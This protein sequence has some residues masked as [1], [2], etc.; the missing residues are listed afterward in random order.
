M[1][2]FIDNFIN[3]DILIGND[4]NNLLSLPLQ[5]AKFIIDILSPIIL[6]SLSSGDELII[7]KTDNTVLTIEMYLYYM[8]FDFYPKFIEYIGSKQI[9]YNNMIKEFYPIE[10]NEMLFEKAQPLLIKYF[11]ISTDPRLLKSFNNRNNIIRYQKERW[12]E[13]ISKKYEKYMNDKV[14]IMRKVIRDIT[15][16]LPKDDIWKYL[17]AFKNINIL[18]HKDKQNV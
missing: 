17:Y 9:E 11:N 14:Q 10:H 18:Y 13:F 4:D 15:V 16:H 3:I 5:N 12:S 6:F 2:D 1:D 7:K 8:Q